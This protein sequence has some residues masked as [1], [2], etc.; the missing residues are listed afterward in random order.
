MRKALMSLFLCCALLLPMVG[1]AR[2][3]GDVAYKRAFYSAHVVYD[4]DALG[5][6]FE[7]FK[8]GGVMDASSFKSAVSI[9]DKGLTSFDE[10]A[11]LLEKGWPIGGFDKARTAINSFKSAVANGAIKFSSPKAQS[12]YANTVATLEVGINLLEAINAGRKQDAKR[13]EGEYHAKATAA[14]AS[15]AQA[16]PTWYQ[17]AIVRGSQL[18]SELTILSNADAVNIWE[19]VHTRSRDT[20]AENAARLR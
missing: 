13:L 15:A 14:K 1:C 18:A 8:N 7:I 16:D 11:E 6:L 3:D 2:R 17:Q 10:I 20:H 19:A 12:T 5:D 9:T 4:L